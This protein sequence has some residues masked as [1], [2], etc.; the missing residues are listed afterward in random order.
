M[1]FFN[2]KVFYYPGKDFIFFNADVHGNY[3]LNQRLLAVKSLVNNE[4]TTI[5]TTIDVLMDRLVPL[6][7][8]K[9][10]IVKINYY[11]IIEPEDLHK[12]LIYL[13][14]ERCEQVE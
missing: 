9:E 2:E 13:G 8:I 3:T 6:Y 4:N 10:N 1:Q 11:T 5:V 14:Y 12:K 7:V